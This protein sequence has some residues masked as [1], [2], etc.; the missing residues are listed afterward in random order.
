[1]DMAATY[2]T[3]DGCALRIDYSPHRIRQA[4]R[5]LA[6]LAPKEH[7][8][9]AG[10]LQAEDVGVVETLEPETLAADVISNAG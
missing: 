5:A 6:N 8:I 1:M 7:S 4:G 9:D 10:T 2:I 3:L